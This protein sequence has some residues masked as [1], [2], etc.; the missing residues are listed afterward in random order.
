MEFKFFL[1]CKNKSNLKDGVS[2]II[3]MVQVPEPFQELEERTSYSYRYHLPVFKNIQH[4]GSVHSWWVLHN[5]YN[6]DGLCCVQTKKR[7][8]TF[9]SNKRFCLNWVYLK[10]RGAKAQLKPSHIV[11]PSAEEYQFWAEIK[12]IKKGSFSKTGFFTDTVCE[13]EYFPQHFLCVVSFYVAIM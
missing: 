8:R 4:K 7:F 9:C 6:F 3:H 2:F 11:P 5:E 12:T 13:E 1:L 10:R